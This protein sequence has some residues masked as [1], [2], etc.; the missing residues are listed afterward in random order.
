MWLIKTELEWTMARLKQ[1]AQPSEAINWYRSIDRSM[2]RVWSL[3]FIMPLFHYHISTDRMPHFLNLTT[4]VSPEFFF[5]LWAH[6][7][8]LIFFSFSF[9]FFRL[10][11]WMY[12]IC[13]ETDLSL[14]FKAEPACAELKWIYESF[15]Q[16]GPISRGHPPWISEFGKHSFQFPGNLYF[17]FS[18]GQNQTNCLF[19]L[20]SANFEWNYS[21]HILFQ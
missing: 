15:C 14:I 21:D 18:F 10:A 11:N 19:L 20:Y 4:E 3:L 13:S 12:L 2:P 1:Q 5:K 17:S 8:W 7:G 6:F 9:F 16:V